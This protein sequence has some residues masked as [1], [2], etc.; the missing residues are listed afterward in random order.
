MSDINNHWWQQFENMEHFALPISLNN[1]SRD[2]DEEGMWVA[3]TN[4]ETEKILGDFLHGVSQGNTKEEA[5]ANLFETIRIASYFAE[6][7]Y[8]SYQRFVPF[9]KG[10]WSH[11]GGRWFVV[12]GIH[13]YFRY[14]KGMRGGRYI[15]F[16]KLNISVSN[17][18]AQYKEFKKKHR[19]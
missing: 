2:K 17:E 3:A 13:F 10:N 18:W 11:I 6:D 12:F 5:I 1:T 7:R 15:P 19:I 14:G 16:T 4:D 8:R 9:R